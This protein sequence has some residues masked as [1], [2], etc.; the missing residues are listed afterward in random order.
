MATM[1][2]SKGS[3]GA[4][5]SVESGPANDGPRSRRAIALS[6]AVTT[7]ASAAILGTPSARAERWSIDASVSSQLMWT[8]N[9]D[10][11]L[12]VS[13]QS[14]S[15]LDVRPRISLRGE[16]ARLRISGS[17]G[18]DAVTSAHGTQPSRVLPQADLN[19]RLEAVERLLFLEAAVRAMQTSQNVFGL[20]P[21]SGST[22]N[23]LTTSLVRF[24]PYIEASA[25]P[26]L[27]YRL[28]SDNSWTSE[29][30]STNSPAASLASGRFGR[31][32]VMLEH[33]PRP[34][35]WRVE[36][37]RAET[38]YD[39]PLREPLVLD[40]A[41]ASVDYAIGQDFSAGVRAGHE[42][43]S[44]TT[45]NPNTTIYGLQAKWQPSSRTTLTAFEEKRFFGRAWRLS[46]DHRMPRLAWNVALSRSLNTT[47]Q[48][49][50]D[51]P[52]TDNVAALLDAMFTTR[53]PDP[54]ERARVVQDYMASQGLPTSTLS[55]ITLYSQ[56]LSIVTLRSARV[57]L[58]GA[59]NSLALSAFQSRSEDALD[60]GP[61]ATG[62][63]AANN[64]Q[65]GAALAWSQRMS[66]TV[67]VAAGVDWSRITSLRPV[68]P[69]RTIQHS[70]SLRITIQAAPKTSAFLGARYRK[71]ES[72]VVPSG[73]DGAVTVG[74]EHRF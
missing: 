24:S 21:E 26:D 33:D 29:R 42:R 9:G 32:S 7:A 67:G 11:G 22:Q 66:K 43:T 47:P 1:G 71:L 14:D 4:M 37:E 58:T 17:A 16:G 34:L 53:F 8:S 63:P 20:R 13:G 40:V 23:A 56:R 73:R 2:R 36:A 10:L 60:A 69:E 61:L 27:R 44:F 45:L 55:P 57:V 46:F 18:L 54:T 64:T 31:H 3:A 28:R 62:D 39:D 19:A 15:V 5:R 70:A 65:Y 51:L 25:G 49:L 12:G 30:T 6:V 72:N 48:T 68:T 41:R 50:A 74:L 35:G 59:R 52:P 38:R